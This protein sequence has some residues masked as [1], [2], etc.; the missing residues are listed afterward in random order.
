M[1]FGRRLQRHW[2]EALLIVA[3]ALPWLAL[4]VLGTVWLWQGG[5][6]W[7]WAITAAALGLLAWPLARFVRRRANQD[8]RV[9][10]GERAA[11]SPAWNVR[12]REAWSKVLAIADTTAPF[13]V[14]EIDPLVASARQIIE[15]VAGR[16]HPESQSPWAQFSVPEILLLTER[17]SRDLRREALRTIP[18]IRIVKL[19][20]VLWLKQKVER[21]GPVWNVGYS[22]WRLARLWNPAAAVGREISRIFDDKFGTV[23]LD[24][25]RARVTQEFVL[26]VGRAAID[27]YSGRLALSEEELRLAR[28]RDAV[29]ALAEPVAPV[30]ILLVGQVNAGKSSLVNALAQETRCN[31]G[32]LPTT[33][34]A[35]E[36][37]LELEGRP[38]VS[39]VDMPGFGDSNTPELLAQAERADLIIWV[40]SAT[41]PARSLDS[42]SLSHFRGWAATQ[43]ARRA[44]RVVLALT[45]V[46]ELRPAIEWMPPY[47]VA[48]PAGPKARNIRA[49]IDSV[50]NALDFPA[51]AIVPVAM[52]PGREPYNIDGLW[53]RIAVELDQAKLVQL[54]RLRVGGQHLNLRELASQLGN[55]GRFIFE[56][57][58]KH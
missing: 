21:Y 41:Q 47:D 36:Y 30:R 53:A 10:L 27:L 8:A 48:A 45:H 25:L 55:A 43:L 49:A 50:A 15:A 6:V 56:S 42:Q 57:V 32:P 20:H 3:L 33:A 46:D 17:V 58:A 52:P 12:E 35:A 31:V 51:D 38:A 14:T 11:P 16:L 37:Q 9:A 23:L 44:P 5:Y 28:E 34:R 13:S 54:D 2:P 4:L 1:R 22:V 39:L 19:G 24:R 7:V 29:P 18:G 40:A 26:E